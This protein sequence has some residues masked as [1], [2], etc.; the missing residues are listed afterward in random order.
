MNRL[1][2]WYKNILKKDNIYKLQSSCLFKQP[3]LNKIIMNVNLNDTIQDSKQIL[4]VISAIELITGQKPKL[5]YSKKSIAAFKLKKYMIIGCKV[6]L[7]R[8]YMFDLLDLF[9]FVILPQLNNFQ[10][11]TQIKEKNSNNINFG[12]N[13]L[14]VFPQITENSQ[15]FI[16]NFGCNLTFFIKSNS[17]VIKNLLINQYQFPKKAF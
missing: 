4:Q 14:M 15:Y 8:K 16:K 10:G 9:N 13:N 6:T 17:N 3:I 2:L 12:I 7:Q 11:L 1:N 5:Y